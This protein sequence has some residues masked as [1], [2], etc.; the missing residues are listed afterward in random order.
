MVPRL[1]FELDAQGT[2]TKIKC[3]TK[4]SDYGINVI[5][6]NVPDNDDY[7]M[8]T[9]YTYIYPNKTSRI[10]FARF[11]VDGCFFFDLDALR[12]S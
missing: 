11:K 7:F 10:A 9:G 1:L 12:G 6:I 5:L 2:T 4:V 8:L 3:G